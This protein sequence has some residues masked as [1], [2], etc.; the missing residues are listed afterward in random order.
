MTPS[1]TTNL[2][3][4]H[5]FP[6]EIISHAVWLYFRFPLSHRDVEELLFV[7]GV[8]VSYEA[9]RKWCR[10]FGAP[11]SAAMEWVEN[12]SACP[13]QALGPWGVAPGG[14]TPGVKQLPLKGTGAARCRPPRCRAW[15]RGHTVSTRRD[16]RPTGNGTPLA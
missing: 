5:R 9:I 16:E 13:Q 1:A 4:H 15:L 6:G 14:C 2:Y 11:R 7:R 3:K 12:P 10:K 8:M